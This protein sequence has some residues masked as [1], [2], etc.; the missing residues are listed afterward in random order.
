MRTLLVNRPTLI[1]AILVLATLL[2]FESM[3]L[4]GD[5][6]RIARATILVIAFGKVSLVGLEFMEL[7]HAPAFLKLPFIAWLVIVCAVLQVLFW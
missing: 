4:G 2:S 3:L 5:G 1:W 6:A 7:R